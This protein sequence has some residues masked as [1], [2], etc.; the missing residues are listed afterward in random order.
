MAY[1]VKDR[2]QV[3]STSTGT[4]DFT[5]GTAVEGYQDFSAL[6]VANNYE[7]TETTYCITDGVDWEVGRGT[8]YIGRSYMFDGADNLSLVDQ[9]GLALG[10]GDFTIEF[11]IYNSIAVPAFTGIFDQRNGTNGLSVVQPTIEMLSTIGYSW[12]VTANSR[13]SSGISAVAVNQWQHV[14]VARSGTN[15]K[16]FVDGVQVGSTYTDTNNYPSGSITIGRANDGVNTRYFTGWLSNFRI[17]IGSALY[18]SNFTVPVEPLTAVSGTEL[19]T[20]KSRYIR[21]DSVNNYNIIEVNGVKST[22]HHPFTQPLVLSRD[23]IYESSNSNGLVNW[24]AGTKNVFV[25]YAA[26]DTQGTI[27]TSDDG[28]VD[29]DGYSWKNLQK[30]LDRQILDNNLNVLTSFDTGFTVSTYS[31]VYTTTFSYFGGVLAPNGDV[32]FIPFDANRGQKISPTGVVSTYSLIHTRSSAYNGGVLAPN[33]DIHFVP[34]SALVGQKV[35]ASGVVSTYSLVYTAVAAYIGGVLD[36]DG[37]VHF[38]IDQGNRGQK[39][40]SL[41]TVS[42]YTLVRTGLNSYAGGVLSAD[43]YIHYVPFSTNIGQKISR[44]GVVSTYTLAYSVSSGFY[45]GVLSYDGEIHFVPHSARVGQKISIDGVVSTYSLVYTTTQAYIGGVLAPNGDI[46]FVPYNAN[47]GQKVSRDGVVST[48]SLV[49]TT[50]AAHYG[51]VLQPNGDIHFVQR[52]G[53]RGQKISTG[54]QKPIEYCLLPFF[55]KL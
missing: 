19:L 34:H 24:G 6:G 20:C 53:V 11:W 49:Y 10:T 36:S 42:T 48:Y 25:T 23:R 15:T 45:G 51:G 5:L 55:N 2:V 17:V 4:G 3:T 9:A 46:H 21:D 7:T 28:S 8:Y 44:S 16:M 40:S 32:H 18:T 43:G 39:V 41:G 12:Y 22:F 37:S 54:L 30:E 1:I 13:I 27:S 38:L 26:D 33:G 52:S 29:T 50:T 31:L 14:A 47:R 35:S